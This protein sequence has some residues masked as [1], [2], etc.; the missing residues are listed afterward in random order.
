MIDYFGESIRQ[1]VDRATS[2]KT[3]QDRN[4]YRLPDHIRNKI[5]K[6]NSIL[7]LWYNTGLRHYKRT[8]NL[9]RNEIRRDIRGL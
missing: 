9:L 3:K 2:I 4:F 6:K 1:A 8:A 5:K 7:K